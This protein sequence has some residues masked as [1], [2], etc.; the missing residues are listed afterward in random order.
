MHIKV[1]KD[2]KRKRK[3]KQNEEKKLLD[4]SEKKDNLLEE[5]LGNKPKEI[6]FEA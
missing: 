2:K 3:E 4:Q 1:A 5:D 6:I